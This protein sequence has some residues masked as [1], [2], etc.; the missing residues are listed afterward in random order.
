M[1]TLS[2]CFLVLIRAIHIYTYTHTHIHIHIH[3]HAHTHIHTCIHSYIPG[4]FSLSLSD[5]CSKLLR[6]TCNILFAIFPSLSYILI[7]K[8]MHTHTYTH[9]HL[10]LSVSDLCSKFLR[11]TCNILFAIFSSFFFHSFCHGLHLVL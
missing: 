6:F 5:L 4:P 1:L 8:N 9:T 2:A 10:G 11:F 7:H 3:I